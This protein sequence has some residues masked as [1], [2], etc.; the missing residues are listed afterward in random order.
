MYHHH[1][2]RQTR[3]LIS[4]PKRQHCRIVKMSYL[5]QNFEKKVTDCKNMGTFQKMRTDAGILC[6]CSSV[7]T[8]AFYYISPYWHLVEKVSVDNTVPRIVFLSAIWCEVAVVTCVAFRLSC[9]SEVPHSESRHCQI[10]APLQYS[11][12][13]HVTSL[14]CKTCFKTP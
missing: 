1:Q 6:H 4:K 13:K 11:L 8:Q 12:E 14:K 7:L 10:L 9:E 3:A 2:I 5:T